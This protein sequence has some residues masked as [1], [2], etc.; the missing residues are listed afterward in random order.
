MGGGLKEGSPTTLT[1]RLLWTK[2]ALRDLQALQDFIALDKPLAAQRQALL[3]TE[4]AERLLEFPEFGRQ[5]RHAGT[6]ELVV[7]RSPFIIAYRVA[8]N[9]IQVL[10]VMHGRQRWP[11]D[12][13]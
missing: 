1:R 10:R 11:D 4:A 6:R 8:D 2:P 9:S 12:L 5:G 3:V 13:G 7:S